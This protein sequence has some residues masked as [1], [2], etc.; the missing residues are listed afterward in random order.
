VTRVDELKGLVESLESHLGDPHDPE[1]ALPVQRV[2]DLDEAEQY[3]HAELDLLHRW[4]CHEYGHP[5]SAGGRGRTIQDSVSFGIAISRR[6]ATLATALSITMLSWM[7][8]WVAGD[9]DQQRGLA[10]AVRGGAKFSWGLSER[11]H[12]S[13]LLA[14]E[15]TARKVPGGYRLDG[16]KW[17]IGNCTLADYVVL[18][19][20]T[21]DRGGPGGFSVLV[22]DKRAA[23]ARA[24]AA[25]PDNRLHGLRGIDMSGLRL[26]DC[27][28]PDSALLGSEGHGLEIALQSSHPVRVMITGIAIGCADTALRRTL[29]FARQRTLFGQSVAEI[30]YS[31]RQLTDA[32]GD[33]LLCD[34]LANCAARSL[35]TA[36]DQSSV[37][38]ATTKYLVPTLLDRT[39]AELGVVLG[40]RH[41]LRAHPRF[42]AFQKARRDLLVAN[43]ADGNTTVNLKNIVAQLAGLLDRALDAGEAQ[44]LAASDRLAA[45]FDWDEPLP[46]FDPSAARTISRTGD[47][48]LLALPLASRRLREFA[49]NP[50]CPEVDRL[51]WLHCAKAVEEFVAELDRLRT[52][53]RELRGRLGRAAGSSAEMFR[54][55]EQFCVVHAAATCLG[56]RAWSSWIEAPL[57][58]PAPL[59]LSL[60][61]LWHWLH[62]TRSLIDEHVAEDVAQTM[63]HLHATAR[64]FGYRQFQLPDSAYEPR[65]P[66]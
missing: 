65:E 24:V 44:R 9:E 58:G 4:G 62:P 47:D 18:F 25:L 31:R 15:M 50:E 53:Q 7:P 42:G 39:V 28:V 40:A 1:S 48:A 27:F 8:I 41:Y 6:D 16:E 64:S 66:W 38:S 30:P 45:L 20:R 36:P 21:S 14:N 19:A 57:D 22:L 63:L 2:L 13:D 5:V 35:Q 17:L 51:R 52:E 34:V 59:L 54:L 61:R 56:H 10:A 55:A 49:E 46:P 23:D 12:G 26:R 29:D 32:F 60:Q 11:A 43:F 3:P 37:W 33:V